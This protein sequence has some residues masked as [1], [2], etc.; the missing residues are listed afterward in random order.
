VSLKAVALGLWSV[1]VAAIREAALAA[2]VELG[3]GERP[4]YLMPLGRPA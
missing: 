1:V 4:I 3:D 2:V